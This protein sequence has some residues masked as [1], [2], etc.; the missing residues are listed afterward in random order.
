[1]GKGPQLISAPCN[2]CRRATSHEIVAERGRGKIITLGPPNFRSFEKISEMLECRGCGLVA[3][4]HTVTDDTGVVI[5]LYD[6]PRN[7]RRSP[8]WRTQL[9][10][11]TFLLLGEVDQAIQYECYRIATMGLR[12]VL[13]IYMTEK[14][15]DVG[16]FKAKLKA[17]QEAGFLA[18]QHREII[19]AALEVGDASAHRGHQP[20]PEAVNAVLDIVENVLHADVLKAASSDLRKSAP[21]RPPR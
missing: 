20:T 13:D 5:V 14:V 18:L 7:S 19:E 3:L 16:G 15:G 9:P 6:P 12:A 17:L 1:M 4:K 11:E 10:L 8:K 2:G 21:S